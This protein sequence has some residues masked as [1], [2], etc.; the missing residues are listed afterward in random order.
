MGFCWVRAG[1][2]SCRQASTVRKLPGWPLDPFPTPA[3]PEAVSQPGPPPRP[4]LIVL[5]C[6]GLGGQVSSHRR[7]GTG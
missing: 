4:S 1:Q 6:P 2:Q 7:P 3:S 5:W